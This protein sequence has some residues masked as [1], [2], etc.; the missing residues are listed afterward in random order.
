MT[1]KSDFVTCNTFDVQPITG[2]A[3]SPMMMVKI[4]QQRM[5]DSLNTETISVPM[6]LSR[7]EKRRLILQHS[8]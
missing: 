7:E 5:L 2:Q 4:D 6:G 1:T 3:H 8:K